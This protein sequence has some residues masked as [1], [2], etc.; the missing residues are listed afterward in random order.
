VDARIMNFAVDKHYELTANLSAAL[1]ATSG[2]NTLCMFQPLPAIVAQHGVEKG[3]NV[4]GLDYYTE[5]Y[6]NGVMFLLTLAVNGSEPDQEAAA[7]PYVE[8]YVAQVEAYAD[9][10][11]LLWDWKY[12]NYAYKTQN[13]VASFGDAAIAKMK[14]ASKKYDPKGVFQTLRTSGF[15]SPN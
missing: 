1:S 12:L 4:M 6:G 13:P 11:G 2:V 9:S 15:K 10:L 7:L 8:A 14:A 5:K 3:G